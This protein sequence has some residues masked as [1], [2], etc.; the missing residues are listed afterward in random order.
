MYERGD[1]GDTLFSLA[2]FR[3]LVK[4]LTLGFRASLVTELTVKSIARYVTDNLRCALLS[5]VSYIRFTLS[6]HWLTS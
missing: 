1:S 3:N 4:R 2:V 6:R 5:L